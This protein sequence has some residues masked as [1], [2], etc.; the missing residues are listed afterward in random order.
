MHVQNVPNV[1]NYYFSSSNMQICDVRMAVVVVA[2]FWEFD[3]PSEELNARGTHQLMNK[4]VQSSA[5]QL[6]ITTFTVSDW[7]LEH[8]TVNL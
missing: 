7:Q 3:W 6:E 4:S 8:I 5:K 1:Q 2:P